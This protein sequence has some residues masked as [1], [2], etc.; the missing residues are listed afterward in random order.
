MLHYTCD[1]CGVR[2]DEQRYVVKVEV[3]PAIDPEIISEADLD[4]DHLEQIA[5]ILAEGDDITNED[6]RQGYRY[7]LCPNC[8]DKYCRDPLGKNS[9][10]QLKFSEN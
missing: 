1:A 10:R 5:E 4:A 2:L 9:W 8:R 7:D 6:D 3:A